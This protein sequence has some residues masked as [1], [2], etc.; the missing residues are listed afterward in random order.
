MFSLIKSILNGFTTTNST[1]SSGEKE[2]KVYNI[3]TN[4]PQIDRE[5]LA[6]FRA[7]QL[8]EQIGNEPNPTANQFYAQLVVSDLPLEDHEDITLAAIS[9]ETMMSL[10]LL[11]DEFEDPTEH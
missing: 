1:E 2:E 8:L 7:S 9:I 3:K 11:G 5:N 4:V 6:L 10:E